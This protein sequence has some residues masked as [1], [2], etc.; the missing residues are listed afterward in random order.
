M[1]LTL[2]SCLNS[3][4]WILNLSFIPTMFK[5]LSPTTHM[6]TPLPGCSLSLCRLWHHQKP[7]QPRVLCSRENR[8][9]VPAWQRLP[10]HPPSSH[11]R[12]DSLSLIPGPPSPSSLDSPFPDTLPSWVTSFAKITAAIICTAALLLQRNQFYEYQNMKLSHLSF[13]NSC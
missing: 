5:C 13:K 10:D 1:F 2:S 6:H 11:Q 12:P 4:W 7:K 8:P 3:A 9:H